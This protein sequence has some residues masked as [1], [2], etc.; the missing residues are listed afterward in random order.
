MAKSLVFNVLK[1]LNYDYGAYEEM[2][3]PSKLILKLI[4]YI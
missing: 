3:W 2:I 1:F 4:N